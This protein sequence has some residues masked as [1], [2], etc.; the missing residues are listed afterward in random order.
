LWDKIKVTVE[1]RWARLEGD[2][3]WYYQRQ[4][5]EEAVRRVRGVKG[6][7]NYIQVKPRVAP[8]DI[9]RK[10]QDALRRA[11]EIDASRITVQANGSEVILL[12]SVRSW[13]EREEAEQAA[14]R[15]PGVAQVDNRIRVEP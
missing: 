15:A 4:N 13:S 11:A 8:V 2:V 10:I 7:S 12:G 14:W 9:R 5:A 3:E 6:V 1:D